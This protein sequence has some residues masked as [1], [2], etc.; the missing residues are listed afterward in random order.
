MLSS[1][2]RDISVTIFFLF[3]YENHLSPLTQTNSNELGLTK[4]HF[5]DFPIIGC[6]LNLEEYDYE[7]DFEWSALLWMDLETGAQSGHSFASSVG[8]KHEMHWREEPN[9]V[10]QETMW[11]WFCFLKLIFLWSHWQ[12]YIPVIITEGFLEECKYWLLL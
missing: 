5:F 12:M 8:W 2:W 1:V 4:R 11:F 3:R 7:D 6:N 10:W 9:T